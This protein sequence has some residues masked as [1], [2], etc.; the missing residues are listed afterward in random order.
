MIDIRKSFENKMEYP[1]E[2]VIKCNE[3]Y[4]D[5]EEIEEL[6]KTKSFL[7]GS[8]LKRLSSQDETNQE[9]MGLY[10]TFEELY[11]QQYTSKGKII[12]VWGLKSSKRYNK[13]E[14]I[15]KGKLIPV[16]KFTSAQ[17]ASIQHNIE[18]RMNQNAERRL[19]GEIEAGKQ[20]TK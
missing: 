6:L 12:T 16:E 20:Y 9:K 17:I 5:N 13:Q 8:V 14:E 18:L 19:F 15:E 1:E 4:P 10:E 11:R 7:L 3:I 2:F